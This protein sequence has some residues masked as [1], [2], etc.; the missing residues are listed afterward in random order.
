MNIGTVAE[1]RE[2]LIALVWRFTREP[3]DEDSVLVTEDTARRS[4]TYLLS[5]PGD[6]AAPQIGPDG[7]GGI[8][9]AWD[10]ES[11]I[12]GIADGELYCVHHAGTPQSR[13]YADIP[14]P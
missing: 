13:H 5:L 4:E 6:W 12:L 3:Q 2:K 1:K 11:V 10:D 7:E 14:Y 9:L 8:N